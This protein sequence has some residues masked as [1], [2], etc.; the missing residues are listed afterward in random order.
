MVNTIVNLT[1]LAYSQ[2]SIGSSQ[3]PI[4]T[5]QVYVYVSKR[6]L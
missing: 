5:I 2:L 1:M 6:G 4:I 3:A